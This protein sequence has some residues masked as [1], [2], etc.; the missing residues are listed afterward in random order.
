MKHGERLAALETRVDN[1]EEVQA[2]MV[3]RLEEAANGLRAL[4]GKIDVAVSAAKQSG[5]PETVDPPQS[6]TRSLNTAWRHFQDNFA[7]FL[8]YGGAGLF[9]WA[10][11]KAV[12][13]REVPPILKRFLE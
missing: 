10:A 12:I 13:F 2:G 8:I 5:C 9:A 7:M 11:V 4:A 1:M 3:E 6:F